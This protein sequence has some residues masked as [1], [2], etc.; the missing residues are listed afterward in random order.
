M[1]LFTNL[2]HNDPFAEEVNLSNT[3]VLHTGII[4]VLFPTVSFSYLATQFKTILLQFA[5]EDI[6]ANKTD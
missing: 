3:P 5:L 4:S 6:I 2:R 1:P